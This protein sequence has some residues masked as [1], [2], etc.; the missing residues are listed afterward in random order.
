MPSHYVRAM[1]LGVAIGLGI[2]ILPHIPIED[3]FFSLQPAASPIATPDR[4]GWY[5]YTNTGFGVSLKYPP[6]FSLMAGKSGPLTEWQLYG[7]TNGNEIASVNIPSSFQVRT[8]FLGAALRIGLS[9]DATAVKECLAPPSA[10]GYQDAYQERLIG[11]QPFHVFTR[12]DV[13]AGNFYEFISYRAV[14]HNG[15]EVFEYYI[16]KTNIQNYPPSA[17]RKE[18]DRDAVLSALNGVLDTVQFSK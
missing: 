5:S 6:L 1:L 12:S 11:G 15:C 13:G 3:R 2:L 9:T 8:N 7:L 18:F 16:H 14:R 10:Y 17:G 4:A